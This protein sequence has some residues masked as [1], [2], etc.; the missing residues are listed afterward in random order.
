MRIYRKLKFF[1]QQK[2]KHVPQPQTQTH[3]HRGL[4]KKEVSDSF[5]EQ[6]YAAHA[7]AG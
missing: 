4:N 7:R 5:I 3:T 6:M 2:E 1:G